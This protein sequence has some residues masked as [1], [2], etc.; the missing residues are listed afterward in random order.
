MYTTFV[1]KGNTT[2]PAI[3]KGKCSGISRDSG[4]IVILCNDSEK[5]FR[6]EGVFTLLCAKLTKLLVDGCS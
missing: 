2:S 6:N 4:M 3:Y 5:P 1:V